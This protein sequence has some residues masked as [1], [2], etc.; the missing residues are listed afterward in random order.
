MQHIG[1]QGLDVQSQTELLSTPNRL[2][3]F[4]EAVNYDFQ[5]N[6]NLSRDRNRLILAG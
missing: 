2:L 5:N 3:N 6:L 1:L 4:P